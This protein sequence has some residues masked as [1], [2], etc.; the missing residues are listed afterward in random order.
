MLNQYKPQLAKIKTIKHINDRLLFLRLTGKF[1]IFNPGQF[2]MLEIPGFAE[3]PFTPTNYPQKNTIDFL[4]QK[5]ENG[6]LTKNLFTLKKNDFLFIRG[7]YGNGFDFNKFNKKNIVLISGGCGL[8]PIKSCLEKLYKTSSRFG[9][10][11]L[12]YGI[13]TIKDFA[14]KSEIK[15]MEDKIEFLFTVEKPEKNYRG[16][17]GIVDHLIDQNTIKQNSVAVLCGPSQMYKKVVPKLINL[18]LSPKDIFIQYERKMSCGVG[19]C[20]H[21]TCGDKHVCTDGPVFTYK[22]ILTMNEN[23]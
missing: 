2:F 20:E 9:Q 13:K 10:I 6:L 4:I 19:H 3:A 5:K 8:A 22:Q 18:G 23:I 11:Q 21:C 14:F 7:P 16:N 17:I 12:F 1:D 15:S